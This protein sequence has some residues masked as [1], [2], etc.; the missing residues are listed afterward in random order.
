[1]SARRLIGV[2][3]AWGERNPSGCAELVWDGGVLRLARLD[4]LGSIDEIVE[5]IEPLRGAW[6]VAVDAPLV[7]RN[8]TGPRAADEQAD[9]F[10]GRFHAGAYPANLERFGGDHRGGRLLRALA[11]TAPGGRLV[12]SRGAVGG[13]RLVFET[14]PHIVT[15]ELFGL[16]RIIKYKRGGEVR[17][18]E[19]QRQL[20]G[21]IREHLCGTRADPRLR[22]DDALDALLREPDPGLR[23]K[24][25]KDREDKLDGLICAYMAAWLDAGRPLQGL[26]DAGFGVMIAPS[27]RG[28]RPPLG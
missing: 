14:Y 18:R 15:V 13:P 19:G 5:W 8:Q 21:R 6:V 2:D 25:L 26:G 17:Q 10:Y 20:A 28:I 3:L 12:E 4:L 11:A 9:E 1:M 16:W 27:L 22:I 24:A 7:I 23:G